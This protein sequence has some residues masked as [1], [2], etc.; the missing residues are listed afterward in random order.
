MNIIPTP[1][2]ILGTVLVATA[3]IGGA[4]AYGYNKAEDKYLVKIATMEANAKVM[5]AKLTASLAEVKV[6][7]LTKYVDKVRVVKEK[8]YVY[9][10]KIITVP[11][12]CELS[13]EWVSIHDSIVKSYNAGTSGTTDGTTIEA[14]DPITGGN[15]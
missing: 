8:E 5:E 10:N 12:K 9:R 15:D 6:D 4:F 1:Y 14:E 7:V 2:K 3:V 11:S 13:S